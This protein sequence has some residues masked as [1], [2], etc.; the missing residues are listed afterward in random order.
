M[1]EQ[2]LLFRIK[3][4]IPKDFTEEGSCVEFKVLKLLSFF[5]GEK[6]EVEI[7]YKGTLY[8]L[9]FKNIFFEDFLTLF[10]QIQ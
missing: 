9:L 1:N 3:F 5:R 6:F 10:E 4:K 7:N 2:L 8:I